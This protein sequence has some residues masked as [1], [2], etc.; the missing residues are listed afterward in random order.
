[1]NEPGT[2]DSDVPPH[3]DRGG[4]GAGPGRAVPDED[5]LTQSLETALENGYVDPKVVVPLLAARLSAIEYR[6][7]NVDRWMDRVKRRVAQMES[8]LTG[9]SER[10]SGQEEAL[11]M[12]CLVL[13]DLDDPYGLGTSLDERIAYDEPD[14]A[15]EEGG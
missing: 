1:M 14:R 8:R 10:T 15:E 6:L 13:K 3:G 2:A 4:Q 12:M 9:L 7:A 11:R 5:C